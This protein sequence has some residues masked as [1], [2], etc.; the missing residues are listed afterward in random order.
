MP[1]A[2]FTFGNEFFA[3]SGDQHFLLDADT[4]GATLRPVFAE[5]LTGAKPAS[6]APVAPDRG[7][8][9]DGHPLE[10]D[11]PANGL[12]MASP[13]TSS[14]SLARASHSVYPRRGHELTDEKCARWEPT[15]RRYFPLAQYT[16]SRSVLCVS[17]PTPR[18]K[19]AGQ[20]AMIR[21]AAKSVVTTSEGAAPLEDYGAKC[22]RSIGPM[23]R[24]RAPAVTSA[25]PASA[26]TPDPE[27]LPRLSPTCSRP[28]IND[29]L[30][31]MRVRT[32]IYRALG[33]VSA[34][35]PDSAVACLLG[36]SIAW[37]L[38]RG[39][40]GGRRRRALLA[41]VSRRADRR[42]Y[43]ATGVGGP[44]T[45]GA[46]EWSRSMR[47]ARRFPFRHS[48]RVAGGDAVAL[49]RRGGEGGPSFTVAGSA[50]PVER[51][52]GTTSRRL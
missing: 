10:C 25:S 20:L 28:S 18:S 5:A 19:I 35:R 27:G 40:I 26:R 21:L 43:A 32:A 17:S 44:L 3:R 2:L 37:S 52:C 23:S 22:S 39:A 33:A 29:R 8:E 13:T 7:V 12:A 31:R 24:T 34:R 14:R 42:V 38:D 45:R 30:Q 6:P 49:R 1:P 50:T 48:R 41:M 51:R 46:A 9:V 4:Y 47:S 36:I 15:A 11:L 16:R